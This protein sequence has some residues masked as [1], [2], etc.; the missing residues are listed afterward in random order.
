[1]EESAEEK[2]LL[3]QSFIYKVQTLQ[4]KENVNA[5]LGNHSVYLHTGKSRVSD[6]WP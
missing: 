2:Q 3:L 1:M 5:F 6:Q 4:N